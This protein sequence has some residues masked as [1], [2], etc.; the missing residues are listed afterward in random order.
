MVKEPLKQMKTL[1]GINLKRLQY[2]KLLGEKAQE[3]AN[4]CEFAH[5][6]VTGTP[7]NWV[8]N[9]LFIYHFSD[10]NKGADWNSAI[11]GWWDE[12]KNYK[13]GTPPAENTGHYTQLAWANTDHI[14]C[15]YI[16][17]EDNNP[18]Y[19]YHKLY[20]CNYAPGGNIAGQNP[21]QTGDSGCENLC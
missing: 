2:S 13:F 3:I 21:Y 5:K 16:H 12:H 18:K 6:P 14:G 4:S 8:A 15:G 20:V 9:N 17:F 1:S 19:K 10:F 11:Q 7:W